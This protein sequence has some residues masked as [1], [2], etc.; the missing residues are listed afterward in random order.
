[1]SDK[2]VTTPVVI[3]DCTLY[4]GDCRE[5]INMPEFNTIDCLVT[6]PP[7][8]M[9]YQSARRTNKH[10]KISG[11]NGLELLQMACDIT[12]QH[13][14]YVFCR[15]DNLRDV[16]MPKSAI[17]WL[18]NNWTSGD[19]EHSH[20][21]QTELI[22]FYQGEKHIWP[23][24]RPSDV[25]DRRKAT[26]DQHPTEKPVDL[27]MQIVEWTKGTVFDPF[28]GSG[29]TGVACAK[30]GRKFLGVEINP[31]YFDLACH[32]IEEAYRQPNMFNHLFEV[33]A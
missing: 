6:D 9:K 24:Y 4:L 27:M 29:T 8:G 13:S 22:L 2:P 10:E 31:K 3:G 30:L 20:A 11:D 15:W 28:M 17:T 16:R 1:M 25:V 23:V 18:K 26:S 5:I 19:L 32:R 21:R 12:P 7:Y 14:S 33:T